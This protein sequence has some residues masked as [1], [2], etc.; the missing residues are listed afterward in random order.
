MNLISNA[1]KV[2]A[3]KGTCK[4][5]NGKSEFSH[6]TVPNNY[7]QILIGYNQYIP[8]CEKCF[9]KENGL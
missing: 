3:L 5:C 7:L 6:R 2:F 9:N 8:L 4:L 1:A